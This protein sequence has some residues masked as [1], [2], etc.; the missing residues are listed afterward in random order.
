MARYLEDWILYAPSVNPREKSPELHAAESLLNIDL[1]PGGIWVRTREAADLW[2][3]LR[4][5]QSGAKPFPPDYDN[6]LIWLSRFLNMDAR[7]TRA[8]RYFALGFAQGA[9]LA[10]RSKALPSD[11]LD[12]VPL[13]LQ[14][15]AR[16]VAPDLKHIH[17]PK[18]LANIKKWASQWLDDSNP[19]V[20]SIPWRLGIAIG[21]NG[22]QV[23]PLLCGLLT[24]EIDSA[25]LDQQFASRILIDRLNNPEKP[26]WSEFIRST[27]NG[28]IEGEVMSTAVTEGLTTANNHGW[29]LRQFLLYAVAQGQRI[30][31]AG[32]SPA[33]PLLQELGSDKVEQIR[34]FYDAHPAPLGSQVSD[35][36]LLAALRYW[37]FQAHPGLF[38][39]N[40]TGGEHLVIRHAYDFLWWRGFLTVNQ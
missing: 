27:Y 16:A 33:Q 26:L 4:D 20:P 10:L 36:T 9:E 31:S 37:L 40:D 23:F 30:A 22:L 29:S 2:T 14:A 3:W 21:Y 8:S 7:S 35:E 18:P 39:F 34:K 38:D 12:P 6:L 19:P 11:W 5:H 28:P 15:R 1:G 24:A 13:E 32:S 25:R 17:G